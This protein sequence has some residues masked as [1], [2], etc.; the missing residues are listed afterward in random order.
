MRLG[1]GEERPQGLEDVTRCAEGVSGLDSNRLRRPVLLAGERLDVYI[2]R[3][4]AGVENKVISVGRAC[5]ACDTLTL[6]DRGL[7][8]IHRERRKGCVVFKEE[9]VG[10]CSCS[11]LVAELTESVGML[12][13]GSDR[14]RR[15]Q[16]SGDKLGRA[17]SES[18]PSPS[19]ELRRLCQQL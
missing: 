3:A 1:S 12:I 16:E 13:R 19:Q 14:R 18:F 11:P 4:M 10:R 15:E 17:V 6:L 5:I 2:H 9:K 8:W 7:K